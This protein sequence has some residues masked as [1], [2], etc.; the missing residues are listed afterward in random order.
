MFADGAGH[1]GDSNITSAATTLYRNG[2]K[3]GAN[4]D[5]LTGDKE[6]KVRPATPPTS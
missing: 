3:V 6:F 2:V 5:R 4:S 1:A